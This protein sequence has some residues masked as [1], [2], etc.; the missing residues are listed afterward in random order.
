MQAELH[1][2]LLCEYSI[3]GVRLCVQYINCTIKLL[4][5][6]CILLYI[7]NLCCGEIIVR[8]LRENSAVL[9]RMGEK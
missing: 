8:V 9:T 3:A 5:E 7:C 2:L 6:T 1:T 4:E